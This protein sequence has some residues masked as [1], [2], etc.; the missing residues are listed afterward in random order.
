MTQWSTGVYRGLQDVPPIQ[1]ERKIKLFLK[2][3]PSRFHHSVPKKKW[4]SLRGTWIHGPKAPSVRDQFYYFYHTSSGITD[5]EPHLNLLPLSYCH[6]IG[7]PPPTSPKLKF[8]TMIVTT[9]HNNSLHLRLESNRVT[10][11]HSPS[12]H[13]RTPPFCITSEY[14]SS[15]D[16]RTH[17]HCSFNGSFHSNSYY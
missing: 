1:V 17:P 14:T 4:C 6:S 10:S 7:N 3:N 8:L 16:F 11:E 2:H 15:H 13:F 12:H 9:C 5:T